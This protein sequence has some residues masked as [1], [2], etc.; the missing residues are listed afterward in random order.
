[1]TPSRS[2][3]EKERERGSE[4]PFFA[5]VLTLPPGVVETRSEPSSWGGP[6]KDVQARSEPSR[7]LQRL[8]PGAEPGLLPL[9]SAYASVLAFPGHH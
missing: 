9:A 3:A 8:L 7:S 5:L 4:P 2:K 6:R 1:M